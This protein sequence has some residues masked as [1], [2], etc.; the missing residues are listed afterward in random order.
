MNN[1]KKQWNEIINSNHD[2]VNYHEF[3]TDFLAWY[4]ANF[5]DKQKPKEQILRDLWFDYRKKKE[6]K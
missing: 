5:P 4:D 2:I 1:D 3:R 6:T